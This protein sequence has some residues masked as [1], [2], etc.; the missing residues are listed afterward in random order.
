M[1]GDVHEVQV[2]VADELDL[3]SFEEAVV[4]L[5]DETSILNGFLGEILDV[6]L[7]ADDTDIGGVAM[8]ALVC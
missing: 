5:T 4:I 7:C 6:G 3:G 2:G 1:A 8:M